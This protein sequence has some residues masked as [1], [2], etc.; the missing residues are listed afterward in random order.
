MTKISDIKLRDF[1]ALRWE[2]PVIMEMGT[3]GERGVLPPVAEPAIWDE[4]G[5]GLSVLGAMKRR[6]APAIPELGQQQLCHHYYHITAENLGSDNSLKISDGTC[7]TKYNPK[8]QEHLAARHAGMTEVHPLQDPDTMQGILEICYR[9]EGFLKELSGMDK[10]S[11]QP[12]GGAHAVCSNA[13]VVRA[14]HASRGDDARTEV[15]TGITT[16]PCNAATPALNG[17]KVITLMPGPDGMPSFDEFKAA[18]SEKTAAFFVTNPED[19]GV[20]NRRIKEF[21]DAAHAVGALCSYDQAN[22]NA[23]LGIARAKEAGFDLCHFNLHKTFSAPHGG[24]GP[25]CGAQGVREF[26]APFLPV[27]TV[28]YDGA[29]YFLDYNR[30]KTIGKV[31]SFYGNIPAVLR[32]YMWC[33]TL[34]ADGLREASTIAVL[35]NQ[36]MTKKIL[37]EVPGVT[38]WFDEGQRRMEQTRFSLEKM[39]EETGCGV[40]DL[41]NRIVDYGI[42]EIWES[43]HPWVV[44]EPFTPEPCES[45]DKN[46]LDYFIAAVKKVCQE[47]YDD[48]EM[49]KGAPYKASKHQSLNAFAEE[50]DEIATT[51]RQYVKKYK[52]KKK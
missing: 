1:H 21:T 40:E 38:L 11:F 22:G 9:T 31:R 49:V 32:T 23:V 6:K 42:S 5:D 33:R 47:C 30:P 35:N 29:R 39:K 44:P 8:V 19:T 25:G 3:P 46:D 26:L 17:Y 15:I 13:S 16:H 28:E 48:P 7:T 36:Y 4:I 14:Y 18:L 45:Y 34:G 10:F 52:N 24:F 2:E 12:G 51:W 41:N 20:F 37:E 43:H 50:Y 27:P